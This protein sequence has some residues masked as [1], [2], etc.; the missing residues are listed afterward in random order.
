MAQIVGRE[1]GTDQGADAPRSPGGRAILAAATGL[2]IGFVPFAPGTWGTLWGVLI[3]WGLSHLALWQALAALAVVVALGVPI[4][5]RAA[6][7]LG[8]DDP[9]AVVYDEFAALPLALLTVPL[10]WT[11]AALGFV[12]FRV[13]DVVKLWPAQRL[14]R[15]HGGWG[16]MADDL[17][18]AVYAGAALWLIARS[19][20][21]G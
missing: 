9:G 3:A 14:E 13:L 4:C 16:I 2:G 18:A 17:A 12:L 10:T 11:S 1:T 7:I 20:V 21:L 8:K 15:L 5:G 19:G 6:R